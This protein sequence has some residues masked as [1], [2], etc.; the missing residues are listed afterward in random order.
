[1]QYKGSYE[2]GLGEELLLWINAV[3]CLRQT[4]DSLAALG[5]GVPIAPNA[6]RISAD[7]SQA[8][9][10]VFPASLYE[11]VLFAGYRGELWIEPGKDVRVAEGVRRNQGGPGSVVLI[12]AAGNVSALSV[13]DLASHCLALGCVC[14]VKLNPVNDYLGPSL[15]DVCAPLVESGAVRFLY[16]GGEVGA[17]L[18]ASDAVEAL[19]I[20]GSDKT[21]DAIVW[22]GKPKVGPA[23]FHRPL[24]AE[25]GCVTP[26]VVVPGEAE[27]TERELR[28]KAAQV[29][30]MLANNSSC[31]CI[32]PKAR[33]RTAYRT[34]HRTLDRTLEQSFTRN[35]EC[36]RSSSHL[37]AGAGPLLLLA[38]A[39]RVPR[40]P[41]RR[42]RAR[43]P[44]R[45]L[46]PGV[47]GQVH[48]V[49]GVRTT[50]RATHTVPTH[51]PTR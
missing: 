25:L 51:P 13:A 32:A 8:I 19:H 14:A 36:L 20:T 26:A 39:P 48:P 21:V 30:F 4:G 27:W 45:V 35:T 11:H 47:E 31:N 41:P 2:S 16:G 15:E 9:A 44:A 38:A 42:R 1:M 43:R 23:P 29:A 40:R 10:D 18:L 49:P 34:A 7:G 24:T 3:T 33:Y 37:R 5:R 22:G 50:R 12:L 46:L 28:G 17:Q 6:V